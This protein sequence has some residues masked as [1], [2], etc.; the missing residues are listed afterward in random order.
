M[1]WFTVYD[2]SSEEISTWVYKTLYKYLVGLAK[3][4]S[5]ENHYQ[6]ILNHG[7]FPQQ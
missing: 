2:A 5:R 7:F 1:W 3:F 4:E 6:I